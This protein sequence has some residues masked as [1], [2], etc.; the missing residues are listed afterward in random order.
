MTIIRISNFSLDKQG[1]G[2]QRHSKIVFD[3]LS[4]YGIADFPVNYALKAF[5][6]NNLYIL[7]LIC[8]KTLRYYP[9]IRII[10]L[11]RSL[12]RINIFINN[13]KNN[14]EF[15][16]ARIV[17]WENTDDLNWFLPMLLKDIFKKK[18]MAFVHNIECLVPNQPSGIRIKENNRLN[19]EMRYLT[20]CD[21]QIV[22]SREEEWFIGL[23]GGNT[24]YLPYEPDEEIS[25]GFKLVSERRRSNQAFEGYLWFGSIGNIPAYNGLMKLLQFN[26]QKQL[27]ETLYISGFETERLKGKFK[28]PNLK[29]L[30]TLDQEQLFDLLSKVKG[31]IVLQELSAGR[32]TKIEEL[33]ISE[34]PVYC[35]YGS[36]RGYW[37]REEIS[38]FRSMD[39]LYSMLWNKDRPASKNSD[40]FLN[41]IETIMNDI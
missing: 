16:A 40:I 9:E 8:Y 17:L 7:L 25:T 18:V 37:H 39:E 14:Q 3:L 36:M 1:H 2:G 23:H 12:N 34:V 5:S 26:E 35:N 22:V 30:G 41:N 38:Y 13:F 10:S 24:I 4:K 32:L 6:L 11:L 21:R 29:I 28:A 27:P 15:S 20:K 19:L 31:V 33:L